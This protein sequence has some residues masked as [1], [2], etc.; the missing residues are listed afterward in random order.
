MINYIK[1]K[2]EEIS[3]NTV[4]VDCNGIGYELTC[5]TGTVGKFAVGQEAKIST[6]M[7]VREDG[8]SL[9]G[10]GSSEEKRMF[11]LLISISGIGPKVAIGVLSGIDSN[12]LAS[13]I[14]SGDVK[15][16]TKVKGLGKKTAERIILEL[17]EKVI[18]DATET[19]LAIES[20]ADVVMNKNMADAVAVLCSLGKKQDDATKLVEAVSKLGAETTEE[21]VSMAF[22]MG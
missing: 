3:G 4:I 12:A 11:G 19:P 7:Q 15:L 16:L 10:F 8:V 6:Y 20:S 22:R 5:S 14:F 21:I 13:A 17:K 18:V 1:G 9:F 2:I